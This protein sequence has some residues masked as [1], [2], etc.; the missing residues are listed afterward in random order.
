M[1]AW[2]ILKC[3]SLWII[4]ARNKIFDIDFYSQHKNQSNIHFKKAQLSIKG[5]DMCLYPALNTLPVKFFK[6]LAW[7]IVNF[8]FNKPLLWIIPAPENLQ[9]HEMR[10][11]LVGM[12]CQW[13]LVQQFIGLGAMVP[14]TVSKAGSF[15]GAL[16]NIIYSGI[17]V[18]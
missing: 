3:S 10:I 9:L 6:P 17:P 11:T 18:P 1:L 5:F 12:F 13:N 4:L 15:F 8:C 2:L 7:T 16:C 14:L